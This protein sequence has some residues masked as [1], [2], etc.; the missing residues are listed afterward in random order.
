MILPLS[1]GKRF[2]MIL[3]TSCGV[4]RPDTSRI[5]WFEAAGLESERMCERATSLTST[6]RGV[7]LSG[8]EEN[9]LEHKGTYEMIEWEM[10]AFDLLV[11]SIQ[12]IIDG[13]AV[14]LIHV[15]R[16]FNRLQH[17]PNDNIRINNRKIKDGFPFLE[18]IP[19][20]T[21]S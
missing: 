21:L 6:W 1:S 3:I 13:E 14:R 2:R 9:E 7:R 5:R 10:Q 18:E 17:W 8:S 12:E 16:P 11:F 4:M 15:L 20:S 19:C